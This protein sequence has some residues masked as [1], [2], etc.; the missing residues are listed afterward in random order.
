MSW[1]SVKGVGT[2]PSLRGWYSG[3]LVI[4]GADN[5]ITIRRFQVQN[6]LGAWPGLGTQPRYKAPG[7]PQLEL[8]QMQ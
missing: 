7:D 8:V 6:L 2:L 4:R 1:S 3:G 5:P